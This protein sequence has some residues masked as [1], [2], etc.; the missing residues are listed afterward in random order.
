M[1]YI[2]CDLNE[3]KEWMANTFQ[4]CGD[5]IQREFYIGKNRDAAIYMVYTDNITN[6]DTIQDMIMTNLMNRCGPKD[7]QGTQKERLQILFEEAIA[8]GELNQIDTYEEGEAAVLLGDTVLFMDGCDYGLVASTKGWPTRGV[9]TAETEVVVQGPKDAF[10][11]AGSQNIVLI[12]RRIRDHALKVKRMKVGTHTQTDMAVLYIKG[13]VREDILANTIQRLKDIKIEG[14]LDSGMAEQLMEKSW[15][16]PFP[17]IQLTERPDKASAALLEGRIVIVVDNTPFVLLIPVTM[18]QLFQA[19]ED[20]YE[21]WEIVSLIRLLR[22]GAAILAV[23]LPGFFVALT[24]WRPNM[25]PAALA[26]K[27]AQSRAGVPLGAAL[28]VLVM[29]IA[30]ELLREAGIRLPS[31]VSSTIGIVGGIIIGQAAVDAGIL[32][33]FVIIVGALTGICTFVIPNNG[34][35]SGLRISK[36]IVLLFSALFGIFGFWVG[37]FFILLHLS[38]LE[39]FGVPY[40]YP[41]CSASAN[42]YRDLKDSIFRLPTFFL[43]KR[44]IFARRGVKGEEQ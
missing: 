44:P 27:I 17:Q 9:P 36:Y 26:I 25:L 4:D 7:F 11:E 19:A 34:L 20:Y 18:N 6:G 32:S 12:R 42:G 43:R 40:L 13:L 41:F 38:G 37:M 3:S 14:I 10:L 35:V 28:E 24:I 2:S 31:P 23:G 21:R 1:S 33:P 5:I 30:F 39:S 8:I 29:E 22:F 16:S 15:F